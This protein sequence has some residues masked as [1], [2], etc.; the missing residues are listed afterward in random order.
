MLNY[1]TLFADLEALYA[2]AGRDPAS[3]RRLAREVE[4]VRSSVGQVTQEMAADYV[5]LLLQ[6][7]SRGDVQLKADEVELLRGFLGF[8]P[9]DPQEEQRLLADL[10]ELETLVPEILALKDEPLRLRHLEGLRRRLIRLEE[11]LPHVTRVLERREQAERFVEATGGSGS[12]DREWL[13]GA[14]RQAL[15]GSGVAPMTGAP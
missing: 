8:A 4:R 5:V 10:G 3:F 15:D 2:G 13:V 7:L 9:D 11:L 14:I 1:T 12:I 6:R